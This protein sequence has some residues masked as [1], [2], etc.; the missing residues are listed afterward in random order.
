MER[1]SNIE[2]LRIIAMLLILLVHANYTSIGWVS[3]ADIEQDFMS[4]FVKAFSEQL[5]VVAVNV[6]ILISGWFG[7]RANLKGGVSLLYQVFFFHLLAIIVFLLL[8]LPFTL[9]DL[10]KVFYFGTAYWFVSSYLVLYAIAPILNAFTE[11][12]SL[13]TFFTVLTTFFLLEFFLGWLG[14]PVGFSYG[15]STM[16]FIGLY[17]LGRFLSK[18]PVKIKKFSVKKDLTLYFLFSLTPV[19]ILFLFKRGFMETAYSS[20]FVVLASTFFFL[21]F[22]KKQFSNKTI[23]YIGCSSFSIYLIHCHP[24]VNPYYLSLMREAYETLGGG[25]Y[26]LFVIGF[27][28]VFGLLCVAL[29]KCRIFSWRLLTKHFLDKVF[30]KTEQATARLSQHLIDA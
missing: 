24:F 26:I 8:G 18:Y 14:N 19:L 13:K 30:I 15:T 2:L 4:S 1:N 23:N 29:D 20:P 10:L 12:A 25:G 5:C 21:A 11:N 6:F 7:I 17:L 9:R 27:S 16:S 28:L 3:I 22:T